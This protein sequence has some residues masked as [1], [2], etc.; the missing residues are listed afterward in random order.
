M[1]TL[2]LDLSRLEE[3]IVGV[4]GR[5]VHGQAAIDL[6]MR[7][8]PHRLEGRRLRWARHAWAFHNLVAHP[9]L[10]LF[11]WAGATEMGLRI[12][13]ATVPRPTGFRQQ[14]SQ[15]PPKR[16]RYPF[17][18]VQAARAVFERCDQVTVTCA[19]VL[20]EVTKDYMDLV[21]PTEPT[22]AESAPELFIISTP[23]GRVY[24]RDDGGYDHL[25][26]FGDPQAFRWV[27]EALEAIPKEARSLDAGR[28]A[29]AFREVLLAYP[30]E[31]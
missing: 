27:A 24:M 6:V 20:A 13:D 29:Q 30:P 17:G 8:C 10:Q 16:V 25:E 26:V 31:P 7:E 15:D 12:H 11:H 3:G 19:S 22:M 2:D 5:E 4:N 9:L 23:Q 18:S 14:P 28:M 1:R 21:D